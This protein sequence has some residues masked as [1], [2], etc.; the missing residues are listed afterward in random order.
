MK[1]QSPYDIRQLLADSLCEQPGSYIMEQIFARFPHK[2]DLIDA[3]EQEL[4]MI[5][6]IGRTKARQIVAALSLARTLMVSSAALPDKIRSPEI[7][8][9]FRFSPAHVRQHPSRRRRRSEIHFGGAGPFRY[10][11]NEPDL[12]PYFR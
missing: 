8:Q 7:I 12:Y 10:R 2:K 4:V 9:T 11:D 1:E 5:K 3:T 6:G